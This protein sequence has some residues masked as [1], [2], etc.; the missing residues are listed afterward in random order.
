MSGCEVTHRTMNTES[1]AVCGDQE[2]RHKDRDHNYT[3]KLK[4]PAGPRDTLGV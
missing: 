3:E 1:C 4:D 2:N